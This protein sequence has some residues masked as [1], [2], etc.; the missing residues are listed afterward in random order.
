MSWLIWF[1][2]FGIMFGSYAIGRLKPNYS[3]WDL[4]LYLFIICGNLLGV[5]GAILENTV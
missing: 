3:A 2:V 4:G 1:N 5:V